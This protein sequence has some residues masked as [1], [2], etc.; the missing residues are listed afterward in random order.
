MKGHVPN[1]LVSAALLVALAPWCAGCATEIHLRQSAGVVEGEGGGRLMVRV[2]ENRSDRKH[3]MTTN[4]DVV[5]EL[6][7]VEGKAEALVREEKEPRWS[8]PDLPPGDYV[9]RVSRL[10]DERGVVQTPFP[11]Q[12]ETFA[13]RANEMTVADVVLSDPRNAWV[14]VILGTALVVGVSYLEFKDWQRNWGISWR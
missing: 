8:V 10:V 11:G 2:F 5:T 6:Y 12:V 9:L 4:K 1:G 14:R 13:I 7:R 3:D